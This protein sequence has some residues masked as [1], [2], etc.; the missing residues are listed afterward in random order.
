M[1]FDVKRIKM[2][3]LKDRL[4]ATVGC[5]DS[6]YDKNT[7][8]VNLTIA[9]YLPL[10]V[11][12]L[13]TEIITADGGTLMHYVGVTKTMEVQLVGV[14]TRLSD[15]GFVTKIATTLSYGEEINDC[16]L[17]CFMSNE[18]EVVDSTLLLL[19]Y[20]PISA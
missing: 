5:V 13:E 10:T 9:G 14:L 3:D 18:V 12:P 20:R 19:G 15:N 7:N 2:G 11:R 17:S 1:Q 8:P 16:D 4:V 6:A